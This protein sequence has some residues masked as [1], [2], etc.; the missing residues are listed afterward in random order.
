V[1]WFANYHDNL[2]S[3]MKQKA[4]LFIGVDKLQA[5]W[6]FFVG[7]AVFALFDLGI[8]LSGSVR[9]LLLVVFL[10]PGALWALY[11]TV[12]ELRFVVSAWRAGRNSDLDG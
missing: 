7:C 5:L 6:P 12:L 1:S 4:P 11:I 8:G 2:L 3:E 9:W 10:L